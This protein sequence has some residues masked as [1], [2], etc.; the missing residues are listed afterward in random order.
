LVAQQR[1]KTGGR[2][3]HVSDAKRIYFIKKHRSVVDC[4]A[5]LLTG[6]DVL[7]EE[8]AWAELQGL[9]AIIRVS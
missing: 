5:D 8:G 2:Q 3:L 1:L 6:F 4:Y 7:D 9:P